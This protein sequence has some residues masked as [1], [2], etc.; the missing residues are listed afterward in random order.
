MVIK[1]KKKLMV[2]SA[3]LISLLAIAGIFYASITL[4]SKS[5]E[6]DKHLISVTLDELQKKID[7]KDS[8]ILVV[9]QTK[10][11][12]CAQ[13]KPVLKEV[14]TKYN[15]YAYEIDESKIATE[16]LGKFKDIA[17]ITGTPTTLF[18]TDGVE[19]T[20]ANRLVGAVTYRKIEQRL[21]ALKYIEE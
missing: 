14:L 11:S 16:D 13:Y 12:H 2:I 6:E 15:I 17:N 3:V 4:N 10:C 5:K 8:F 7:N 19:K 9:T 20:T 21:K 1:M 18:F